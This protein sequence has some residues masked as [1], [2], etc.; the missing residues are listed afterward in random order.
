MIHTRSVGGAAAVAGALALALTHAP[1]VPA[2]QAADGPAWGDCPGEPQR[3]VYCATLD[4]P[5][6]HTDPGAGTIELTLSITGRGDAPRTLVVNPGGPGAP[7]IGTER[8]VWSSLPPEVSE[9]YNVVSFDPRGV[10]ASTPLECGDADGEPR[11]PAPPY[12]PGSEA[13]ETERLDAARQVA[14]EC[15][16][17]GAELLPHLTT[18]NAARDLELIRAELGQD[19]LDF[20]GYSYGTRLGTTYATLFP[21]RTGRM[22]LDSVRDPEDGSWEA[23]FKQN[24]AFQHRAGQFFAWAAEHDDSYGLGTDEQAV[25]ETW[26]ATREELAREPAGGR[27]GS[28]ELDDML[29]SAMYTDASWPNLA[30]AV[31]AHRDGESGRLL[32]AVDQLAE[33]GVDTTLLAYT[34]TDDAWP[35][36]WDTWREATAA[37]AEGAPHFAWLNTW[38]S[39][40]CVFWEEPA[41]EPVEIGSEELPPML[42]VHAADDPATPLA[43]AERMREALPESRLVVV[44]SGNHGQF[45]FEVND[46]VDDL[47]FRYLL[48]GELPESGTTCEGGPA[49]TP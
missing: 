27:A 5:L 45:L 20:L 21:E 35:T 29:A 15:G 38:Y 44:D 47:G 8:Q 18:E 39:A 10:G 43:G 48:T 9:E 46:C 36:A 13:E 42:L 7:G 30:G 40:P 23:Q 33:Q 22:V 31:A 16:A 37:S 14:A 24:D 25:T 41:G 1:A 3:G 2:A 26:D 12:E 28:A 32:A 49:P 34:C 19:R 4:V 17:E 6:D 11:R